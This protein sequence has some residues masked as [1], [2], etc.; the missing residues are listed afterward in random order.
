MLSF[1]ALVAPSAKVVVVLQSC[2]MSIETFLITIRLF[3][4]LSHQSPLS[5]HL[6]IC[7]APQSTLLGQNTPPLFPRAQLGEFVGVVVGPRERKFGPSRL[8]HNTAF[9]TRPLVELSLPSTLRHGLLSHHDD[10]T[11]AADANHCVQASSLVAKVRVCSR[12]DWNPN[13]S[14]LVRQ[15][16]FSKRRRF[17]G[18]RL[19]IA[20]CSEISIVLLPGWRTT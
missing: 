1:T 4:W 18:Q 5:R 10:L 16:A 6:A 17:L 13:M 19:R 20:P 14:P 9:D 8:C 2:T 12:R 15:T 3:A 7:S 11:T